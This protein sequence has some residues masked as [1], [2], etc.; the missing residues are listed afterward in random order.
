MT[1]TP[2]ALE[3]A[4]FVREAREYCLFV[5]TAAALPLAK[6]LSTAR[7]RL[8]ALYAAA[9]S[10]PE[11]PEIDDVAA[12]ASPPVPT[13]WSGF[14]D[15]D[16]YWEI[17]DPYEQSEPVAGSLSDDV[18]DVYQDI[19]RGLALW[20]AAHHLAAIWQWRF[21]FEVHWGDHAIDA[22]RGLHRACKPR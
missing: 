13:D 4:A 3:V 9:T 17:F 11:A 19:A 12:E 14:D 20:D 21:H 2:L 18:L 10:L 5:Q 16:I 1:L 15:K 7:T 8:L 6:R 22:L